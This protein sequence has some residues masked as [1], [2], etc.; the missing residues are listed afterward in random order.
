MHIGIIVSLPL[1]ESLRG[2]HHWWCP[3]VMKFWFPVGR[4]GTPICPLIFSLAFGVVW[5]I[6]YHVRY[7][8]DTVKYAMHLPFLLGWLYHPS[9]IVS[10]LLLFPLERRHDLRWH[11]SQELTGGGLVMAVLCCQVDYII[12]RR[13]QTNKVLLV[14]AFQPNFPRSEDI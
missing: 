2:T 9:V 4:F 7:D 13:K 3:R 14:S 5:G 1:V 6:L 10:L 11:P 8:Y 12:V